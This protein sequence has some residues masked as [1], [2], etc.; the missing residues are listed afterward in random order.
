[1]TVRRAL[2]PWACLFQPSTK[3]MGRQACA[4]N[5]SYWRDLP[6]VSACVGLVPEILRPLSMSKE[7][8][9]VGPVQGVGESF[10]ATVGFAQPI[11]QC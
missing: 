8:L 6:A 11:V 3:D 5:T 10:K 9:S 2:Y 7:I 4:A 1:M